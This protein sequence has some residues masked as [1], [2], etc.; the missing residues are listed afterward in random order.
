MD[1]H[2]SD[3]SYDLKS[4]KMPYLS[5]ALLSAFTNL[6]EG[7]LGGL[8]APTLL[9]NAGLPWLREQV[10]DDAPTYLPLY[11]SPQ[12]AGE[13]QTIDP[14]EWPEKV[15]SHDAGFHFASI[16]DYAIAYRRGE[17]SPEEIAERVLDAIGESD[18][19]DPPLRAMIAVEREDVLAQAL[20]S[21][22]RFRDG[23]ALSILDGVPVAVKDE[24]DMRPYPTT[25]GT[26]F[27]GNRPAQH[28]ATV[29]ARLRAAGALLI[30]KANMHEIGIGVTG[31]NPIHGTPRNP[32]NPEHYTGGSSSG[33]AAAVAAGLCPLA[34]GADG[35]GSIRTPS[36]FCG[37]V[38]LKATYGRISEYGAAP[39]TW[40]MGHIGPLAANAV[41]AAIGY[42]VMAGPDAKDPNS[43]HQP[44][45]TLEG[46]GETDLSDLTLGIYPPWFQHAVP[47]VVQRC[48]ALLDLLAESGA[49]IHHITIPDL[50][51]ARVAHVVTIAS[52]MFQALADTYKRHGRKH[53]LDV[54]LNLALANRFTANDYVLAQRV[55]TRMMDNFRRAFKKVDMVLTPTTA[56]PAPP[57]PPGALSGGESDLSIL[58][59]IMRFV[60]PANLIGLPAIS[61]PA[62]YTSAG[63][64][65]GLQAIGRPWAEAS[66]LRLAL[67]AE[68]LVAPQKPQIYYQI[69]RKDTY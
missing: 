29:V 16:Y 67:A 32:Y 40:S 39:L 44:A 28:D 1:Q 45:P 8:F 27:L 19:A 21:A 43:W 58:M 38:G 7:P 35:G 47:G 5:G 50:E 52:E 17:T 34:V 48:Q 49:Q 53:N 12:P 56:V 60:T 66:L 59:E 55:R 30:G 14:S 20:Q 42:A 15:E 13:G 69:L 37:L 33:P 36:A 18:A 26:A 65:V 63:L 61:I 68:K 25:V 11:Y 46:W 10:F 22:Q 62:G 2:P 51:A 6:V 4:I 31:L 64:P 23:Q 3:P 54:R 9:K 24:I 57:I 41:D